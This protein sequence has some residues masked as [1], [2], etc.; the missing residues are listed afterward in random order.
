MS[1]YVVQWYKGTHW[2]SATL[3]PDPRLIT[4]LQPVKD[5]LGRTVC[6]WSGFCDGVWTD[7]DCSIGA[8]ESSFCF[9]GVP[10]SVDPFVAAFSTSEIDRCYSDVRLYART[11]SIRCPVLSM[12]SCSSAPLWNNL[13]AFVTLREWF[14]LNP[15]ISAV[16]QR[17]FTVFDSVLWPTV[18]LEYQVIPFGFFNGY[19]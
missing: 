19:R 10:T 15:V 5:M 17:R 18:T 1:S 11:L 3:V 2:L 6:W 14:V 4:L 16:S 9:F 8:L 7:E 13:V 12:I